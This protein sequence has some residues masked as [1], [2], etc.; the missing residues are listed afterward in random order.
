MWYIHGM[1]QYE[2]IIMKTETVEDPE[3]GTKW[4]GMQ[5]YERLHN[6]VDIDP[7]NYNYLYNLACTN[8]VLERMFHSLD[9]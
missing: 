4:T 8:A 1:N 6:N 2:T 9:L 3:T 5:I 7:E